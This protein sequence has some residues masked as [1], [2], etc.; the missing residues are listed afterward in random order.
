MARWIRNI[1]VIGLLAAFLMPAIGFAVNMARGS[2]GV[3]TTEKRLLAQMPCFDGDA[4]TYTTEF[5]QF[6]EDNF[7]FRM[8]MIRMARKIKDNLGEDPPQVVTGQDGWLFLG[9]NA[10]RDEFEGHGRWDASNVQTWVASLSEVKASLA[11]QGIPFAAFVAVDKARAY[12]EKLPADWRESDRRFRT[13]LHMSA[14]FAQTGLIDAEPFVQSAKERSKQ[15]FYLRDTHWTSDGTYDLAMELMDIFDPS[16]TRPRYLPGPPV[17]QPA[18]RLF[19]LE[20]MAGFEASEEPTHIMI[21]FPPTRPNFRTSITILEDGTPDPGQFATLKIL[22]TEEAPEGTLVIVGD[23]FGD[24]MLGHF[25]PSYS[26]II[27]IHHGAHFKNVA[28]EEALAYNPDAVLFATAE[29]QAVSKDRP[30]A[31]LQPETTEPE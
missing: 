2:D 30:F 13:A 5:D 20:A 12:P 8:I 22:G 10:Y 26:E 16:V 7:G 25:R 1:A 3:S 23:S 24:A 31:P 15:T 27:R 19:D 29:R 4:R 18:D 17:E 28:L 11:E 14:D 21:K 9:S 6:L